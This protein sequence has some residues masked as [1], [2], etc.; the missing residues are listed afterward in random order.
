MI[1]KTELL[2]MIMQ[3]NPGKSPEFILEQF[4]TYV[5]GLASVHGELLSSCEASSGNEEKS[6]QDKKAE[7][8]ATKASLTCGYVKRKLEVKP[9]DAITHDSITCCI[10][11]QKGKT[12]SSRH[13]ARHNG[14]TREGYLKL[15]GYPEGTV[16]MA[17]QH[18]ER[19]KLHVL[20]A[21]EARKA[22]RE[23]K[24]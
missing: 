24:D 3:N 1:D 23:P 9:E 21:Q 13:L 5:K 8:K 19:M 22:K 10:C 14:I 15:C 6:V 16:L 12:I 11:G 20:R 4:N 18:L 7:E 17:G 2:R